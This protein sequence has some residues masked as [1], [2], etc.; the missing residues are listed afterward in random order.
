MTSLIGLLIIVG[1]LAVY[2]AL[3]FV[4]DIW[5]F[6]FLKRSQAR[7]ARETAVEKSPFRLS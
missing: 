2:V 1:V 5:G 7:V 6:K 3:C 4:H